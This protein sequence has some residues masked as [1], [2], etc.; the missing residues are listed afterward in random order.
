MHMTFAR[1]A[2]RYLTT[3]FSWRL[4][5]AFR[6]NADSPSDYRAPLI[7]VH[8]LALL[9]TCGV[10]F[11]MNKPLLFVSY[12]GAF[13]QTTIKLQHEWTSMA[14]WASHN[15]FQA[16]GNT[17]YCADTRY[18]PGYALAALTDGRE[19]N[20]VSA[21]TLMAV[22]LFLSALL[23]GW[24]LRLGSTIALLGAW[25]L[26]LL[27]LPFTFPP[28]L[29]QIFM[30]CPHGVE[31]F[32]AQ[33]LLIG[34]FHRVG[35][36]RWPV[37]VGLVA[38]MV[39]L[40]MWC[41]IVASP[42]VLLFLPIAATF[43]LSSLV[44]SATR[45]ERWTK[46]VGLMTLITVMLPTGVPY[47]AGNFMYSVSA[48]FGDSLQ[49]MRI[50]W[51]WVS[52][53]FH[54]KGS[55]E[56]GPVLFFG[57]LA[58]GGLACFSE[59]IV[60][61]RVAICTLILSMTILGVGQYIIFFIPTYAGPSP[62]YFEIYL[63]PFYCLMFA[64]LL[65][66]GVNACMVGVKG[67]MWSA[68]DTLMRFQAPTLI[69]PALVLIASFG[70]RGQATFS[71][72]PYPPA[73][74]PMVETLRDKLSLSKTG[75]YRGTVATFTGYSQNADGVW[76]GD[77]GKVDGAGVENFKNDYRAM[78]L[79]YFEIPT[80]FEYNQ[81]MTPPYYLMMTRMLARPQDRQI[82]AVIVL[83]K[84]NLGYLR[85]LGVRFLITDY[86]LSE[87]GATL[88]QSDVINKDVTLYLYELENANL[89]TYS[90]TQVTVVSSAEET[91]ARIQRDGFDFAAEAIADSPLPA[92]L[93]QATESKMHVRRG[94]FVVQASSPGTS[95]LLL[96]LQYSHCL[97]L[98]VVQAASD[99]PAP[100]L[101]RLNVMQAGLVFTGSIRA[102][103]RF[104]NGPFRNQFGR[105]EDYLDF[106]KLMTTN[107][108]PDGHESS[109]P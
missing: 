75:Q 76:W 54:G 36:H 28:L 57:S 5:E 51:G 25:I 52:I 50:S 82:R 80:L 33:F 34:M 69:L 64:Y 108:P 84:P 81:Y 99:G 97:E 23:M 8:L 71:Q 11:S 105:I 66:V 1:R 40:S 13:Y 17:F 10:V 88:V 89:A 104:A 78:G 109:T 4:P 47:F 3:V 55:G 6:A 41:L 37:S 68:P 26:V 46:A 63:W 15:P 27:A 102:E 56:L 62:M 73:E 16:L 61:R 44:G 43:V 74:T 101:V 49:N 67:R 106:K 9:V 53:L 24:C 31:I 93:V 83:T 79:W 38:G 72:W 85:S 48:F 96:P 103:I 94:R 77:I 18:S 22:E 29:Y 95:V 2:A 59:S 65:F 91:I 39:G 12:D 87:P 92:D 30:L 90:P 20:R 98:K 42:C 7:P 107:N 70:D 58:G 14:P 21:Y 45:K 60:F 35:Q 32:A 86:V 19:L 100:K